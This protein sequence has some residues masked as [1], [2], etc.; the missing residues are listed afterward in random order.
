MTTVPRCLYLFSVHICIWF[1]HILITKLGV[2]WGGLIQYS[3]NLFARWC[4]FHCMVMVTSA[5]SFPSPCSLLPRYWK[6]DTFSSGGSLPMT[7]L[8]RDASALSVKEP[9]YVSL[10]GRTR[11]GRLVD[12][13]H[14]A[15]LSGDDHCGIR[16][17]AGSK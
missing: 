1:V 14:L 4:N 11:S 3:E 15:F 2:G 10:G 17:G 8:S 7:T 16:D 12:V 9:R 5:S 6:W 13:H